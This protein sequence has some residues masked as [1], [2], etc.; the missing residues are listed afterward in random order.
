M[1]LRWPC[2][3]RGAFGSMRCWKN[4]MRSGK[5][6]SDDYK[7]KLYRGESLRDDGVSW[8]V[9]LLP[10]HTFGIFSWK[11]RGIFPWLMIVF[12]WPVL[13]QTCSN[14]GHFPTKLPANELLVWGGSHQTVGGCSSNQPPVTS[15]RQRHPKNASPGDWLANIT[16]KSDA[17]GSRVKMNMAIHH[18]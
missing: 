9:F 15:R 18:F 11:I 7:L 6:C 14:D 4:T 17:A 1:F 8:L 10:A 12:S 13:E 16:K 2:K 5:Y 3:P